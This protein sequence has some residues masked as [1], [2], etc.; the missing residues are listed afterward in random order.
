MGCQVLIVTSLV[1]GWVVPKHFG[2]GVQLVHMDEANTF[3]PYKL[4]SLYALVSSALAYIQP[5]PP[6]RKK[7]T[8][9]GVNFPISSKG[10]GKG[11]YTSCLLL[12][13]LLS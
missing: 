7:I 13:P 10:E 11:L 8:S 3:H 5:S 12:L 1:K 4:C 9:R 6:L 2:K